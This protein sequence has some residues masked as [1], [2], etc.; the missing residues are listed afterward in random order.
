V[1]Q[2]SRGHERREPFWP[3]FTCL[4]RAKIGPRHFRIHSI[5]GFAKG[6]SALAASLHLWNSQAVDAPIALPDED[7]PSCAHRNVFQV[8][9][10]K[11]KRVMQL[12]GTEGTI[13]ALR[14]AAT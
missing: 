7:A 1:V 12:F 13:K 5:L 6:G 8:V 9:A 14:I 10:Y 4:Q 3:Q 11:L 2:W